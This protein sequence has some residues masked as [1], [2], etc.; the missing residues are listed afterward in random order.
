MEYE[1]LAFLGAILAVLL[2]LAI[3]ASLLLLLSESVGRA[4]EWLV[5]ALRHHPKAP[6]HPG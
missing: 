5:R 2:I 6:H 3:S 4:W 1:G